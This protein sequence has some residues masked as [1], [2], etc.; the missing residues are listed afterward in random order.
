MRSNDPWNQTS[1]DGNDT[2][3]DNDTDDS[4]SSDWLGLNFLGVKR[5]GRFRDPEEYTPKK[6]V[7]RASGGV[8]RRRPPAMAVSVSRPPEDGPS[9]ERGRESFGPPGHHLIPVLSTTIIIHHKPTRKSASK[10]APEKEKE[11]KPSGMAKG[12]K[13][14]GSG[15]AKRG[16]RFS[17]IF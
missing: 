10:K 13:V 15:I 8:L 14:R 6:P 7:K 1:H 3:N 17:G 9:P 4:Q 11:E 12:G 5:G 2:E 16:T